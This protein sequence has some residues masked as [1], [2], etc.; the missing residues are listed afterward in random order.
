MIQ[1]LFSGLLC[2]LLAQISCQSPSTDRHSTQQTVT[3][4]YSLPLG[5]FETYPINDSITVTGGYGSS[6]TLHPSLA[7]HYYIL[8]DRGPNYDYY[9]PNGTDA[10][11]FA[12]PNYVPNMGLFKKEGDSLM[13]VR[14]ILLRD[15]AGTPLSGIPNPPGL[16]GTDELAFTLDGDTLEPQSNGVDPEGLV[17]MKDGTFWISDEY[18][19]YLIHIDST[20]K[21]I[22][23]LSPYSS[24]TDT[25]LPE[26][27]GSRRPNRGM[28]GITITPDESKL[29]GI[30]QSALH[31]PDSTTEDSSAI[32]RVLVLNLGNF[33]S[34][35]FAYVQEAPGLANSAILAVS[36]TEFLILERDGEIPRYGKINDSL[37]ASQYKRIYRATIE[38]ATD[39]SAIEEEVEVKLGG[40][41][42]EQCNNEK[43][44]SKVGI[45]PMKK[46]LVL[47][48]LQLRY[49]YPHEKPEGIFYDRAE[50]VVGI[51]N[52]ND[53]GIDA[54]SLGLKRKV[55]EDKRL[56][57]SEVY[58]IKLIL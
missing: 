52:D 41:T 7:N 26:I 35:L 20:G 9:L 30:M 34:Q 43:G 12:V 13:L 16:G 33:T 49:K 6:I 22:E 18:G 44:L 39:L 38:G 45:V 24:L 50:N 42:I 46:T 28:E 19:P 31:H 2:L 48:L 3:Y 27:L 37:E 36:N 51:V 8:T 11:G 17:A 21:T 4:P 32:T 29:V 1:R 40:K 5:G 54:D 23:K 10:K 53:Y 25:T 14:K 55:L 57:F 58:F 47:D 56:D 15:K